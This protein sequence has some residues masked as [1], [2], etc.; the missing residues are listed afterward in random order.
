MHG[1]L[2]ITRFAWQEGYG[3]FTLRDT[4][5]DDVRLYVRNQPRHHADETTVTERE[6]SSPPRVR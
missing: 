6:R 3:A 5:L 4:E 1:E 2:G